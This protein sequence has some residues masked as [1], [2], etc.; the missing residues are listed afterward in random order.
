MITNDPANNLSLPSLHLTSFSTAS[1]SLSSIPPPPPTQLASLSRRR[2][3]LRTQTGDAHVLRRSLR[4]RRDSGVI[5]R[6]STQPSLP[7]PRLRGTCEYPLC[8]PVETNVGRPDGRCHLCWR[9]SPVAKIIMRLG[10]QHG[11]V[12]RLSISLARLFALESST[13]FSSPSL[14]DLTPTPHAP[15]LLKLRRFAHRSLNCNWQSV[16]S[17]SPARLVFGTPATC[18]H[19]PTRRLAQHASPRRLTPSLSERPVDVALLLRPPSPSD[20]GGTD[21]QGRVSSDSPILC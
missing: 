20:F 7:R 6:F 8:H 1:S 4:G 16:R 3:A 17:R 12:P 13:S 19:T 2:A 9:V 18:Q 11:R 5:T 15:R 21:D 14:Q 10:R